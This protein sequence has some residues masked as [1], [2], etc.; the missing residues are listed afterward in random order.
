MLHVAVINSSTKPIIIFNVILMPFS[1]LFPWLAN[2][3]S[4]LFVWKVAM[5]IA[6]QSCESPK[7]WES[8]VGRVHSSCYYMVILS[9]EAY[10]LWLLTTVMT[11]LSTLPSISVFYLPVN[12]PGVVFRNDML[13]IL[14]NIS[15]TNLYVMEIYRIENSGVTKYRTLL[16]CI[17]S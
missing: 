17:W 13:W 15:V 7:L 1:Y 5:T 16:L 11:S 14:P 10:T 6:V 3:Q 12:I 4:V 2:G 9:F 8:E